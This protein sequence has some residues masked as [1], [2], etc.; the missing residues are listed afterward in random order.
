M[1]TYVNSLNFT[2]ST[3]V[4][5]AAKVTTVSAAWSYLNKPTNYKVLVWLCHDTANQVCI[6][7]PATSGEY[8]TSGQ[9]NYSSAFSGLSAKTAKWHWVTYV[10]DG[11]TSST[12][13]AMNP[14]MWAPNNST[15]SAY[16]DYSY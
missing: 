2:V 16:I 13:A 10:D 6:Q 9:V 14:A 7:V 3:A 5:T 4:P 8:G 12:R 15:N 11:S 1:R